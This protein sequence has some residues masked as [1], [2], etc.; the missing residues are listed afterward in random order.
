L[1]EVYRAGDAARIEHA[2]LLTALG[3]K[4]PMSAG[5]LWRELVSE[6]RTESADWV[7]LGP[8]VDDLLQR[9]PLARRLLAALGDEPD[10]RR[11]HAV[12]LRLADCLVRGEL[13]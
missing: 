7:E 3:R 13:F 1:D 5:E 11:I 10:E 12:W 4:H 6:L 2:G 8:V 9:G